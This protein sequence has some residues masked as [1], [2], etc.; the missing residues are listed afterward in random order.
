M[1][2]ITKALLCGAGIAGAYYITGELMH[3]MFLSGYR[4]RKD[5]VYSEITPEKLKTIKE[6]PQSVTSYTEW[7]DLM[8]PEDKVIINCSGERIHA[9]IIRA[10]S[11]S[12]IW[13]ISAH[14]YVNRPAQTAQWGRHYYERGFNLLAPHARAHDK[15]EHKYCTM[16]SLDRYDYVDWINYIVALEPD[17]KIILHGISMGGATVM[18]VTGEK[19]PENVKCC[20]EDCGFTDCREEFR[21]AVRQ[22]A[23]IPTAVLLFIFDKTIKRKAGWSLNDCSPLEA[24]KHSVTPTLFIHGDAD[25]F[26]P[27]RMQRELYNNASC[28][29]DICVI[30]KA[31]HAI[32][33]DTDPKT[34]INAVDAFINK[35]I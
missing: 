1:T 21:N 17:A 12:N 23:P 19:L 33:Y 18:L 3:Y 30:H 10:K 5:I 32:S 9:D 24:V 26:V 31:E 7:Y 28:E 20:I 34:Y 14:G 11:K 8:Q 27:F 16:G 35:Y 29:K 15:S 25:K 2:K 22:T 6:N 13:V 4:G